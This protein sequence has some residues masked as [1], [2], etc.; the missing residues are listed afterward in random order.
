M[1]ADKRKTIIFDGRHFENMI[2]EAFDTQPGVMNQTDPPLIR[3]GSI[4]EQIDQLEDHTKLHNFCQ[5]C[6]TKGNSPLQLNQSHLYTV[7]PPKLLLIDTALSMH[8]KSGNLLSDS[9]I[10]TIVLPERTTIFGHHYELRGTARFDGAD[11][12]GSEHYFAVIKDPTS[13]LYIK[14]DDGKV[15]TFDQTKG[16]SDRWIRLALYECTGALPPTERL[17]E[18]DSLEPMVEVPQGSLP[19]H[20][21]EQGKTARGR[22]YRKEPAVYYYDSDDDSRYEQRSESSEND[23]YVE[24]SYSR[25]RHTRLSPAQRQYR[26]LKSSF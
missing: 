26:S 11:T 3:F 19:R 15:S 8:T 1:T 13:G 20:E 4:R 17:N 7:V 23:R 18:N 2:R 10:K 5:R 6:K 12:N 25:T 24:R 16:F 9:A 22:R 21:F 14:V